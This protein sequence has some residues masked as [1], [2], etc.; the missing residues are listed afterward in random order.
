[1]SNMNS[2][3]LKTKDLLRYHCSCHGNVVAVAMKYT[4]DAYWPK[5][6]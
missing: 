2:I 1:M 6:G 4:A 3:H 5:E